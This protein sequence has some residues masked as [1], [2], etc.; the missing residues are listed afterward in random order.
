MKELH[1]DYHMK[2][3]FDN[4]VEKHRFTLK[5]I[6]H[7][8]QRQEISDLKVEIFPKEFLSS[9]KDSFGN[10]CIYGYS[11]GKHDHFSAR[12]T[13]RARTGLAS[14]ESAREDYHIGIYKYQSDYTRPGPALLAFA[15]QFSF[16]PDMNGLDKALTLM[17]GLY[18]QFR[19]VQGVTDIHTTAEQAMTLGEGVCQDYSH[20]LL[21]LCR[22]QK[23]PARYVVGMLMGEGLSHA[24]VE[25][26]SG[27]RWYALDPTNN[28]IVDDQHICISKGRDYKDCIIN[29]G[30]FVGAARQ[31]QE[32]SVIVTEIVS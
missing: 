31:T 7:S 6:P 3:S 13:G 22:M 20:I 14:W 24:W 5:C 21:S 26:C 4:P 18:G 2:L 30:V 8:S 11:E 10:C 1:F 32:A 23:I 27:G 9:S 15:Q 17:R 12:V 28:L 19:Y 29:Q 25:V 16:S